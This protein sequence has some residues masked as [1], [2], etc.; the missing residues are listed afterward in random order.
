MYRGL[1]M[2]SEIKATKTI[3]FKMLTK[4]VKHYSPLS[5]ESVKSP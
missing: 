3:V 5:K 2:H 1:G 4:A